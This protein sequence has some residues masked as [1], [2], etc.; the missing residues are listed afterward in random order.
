MSEAGVGTG[1]RMNDDRSGLALV[2]LDML[3]PYE[4]PDAGHLSTSVETIIDP[5]AGLIGRAAQRDDVH[6]IYVND[7]HG[8]FSAGREDLVRRAL[9]G[10][11]PDMIKPIVPEPEWAFLTKARHSAFYSTALDYLLGRLKV[12]TVI[13]A[14]QVTEQCVLYS[15]LDAYVR[16][17]S[18]RVVSDAVAHIDPELGAAAIRMMRENM[19]AGV[20]PAEECLEM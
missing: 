16:H 8:D 19:Q 13:L 10:Q 2:V 20:V 4:H 9:Q 3:N 7:N 18:V 6:V 17:L 1:C 14:G 11:R 12:S 15:A 5:L